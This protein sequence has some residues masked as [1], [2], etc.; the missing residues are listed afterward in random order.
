[1]KKYNLS[2]VMKRA[3][4][5]K[6]ENENNIFG[7]CLRMAWEEAK[8][9]PEKSEKELLIE[10][11][12]K[13]AE[14]LESSANTK[15]DVCVSEWNNYGKSRTYFSILE[16]HGLSYKKIEYGYYN[17]QTNSYV[18]KRFNDLAYSMK[19]RTLKHAQ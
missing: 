16:M 4:E 18:A 7:L 2:A 14:E 19:Y 15:Y 13:I 8:N 11:L 6:K 5:I 9:V 10:E 12:E 1:M 17:N 3:W